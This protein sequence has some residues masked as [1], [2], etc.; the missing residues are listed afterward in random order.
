M[1][2]IVIR[3]AVSED[4]E[5][6]LKFIEELACYEKM[7]DAVKTNVQEIQATLFSKEATAHALICLENG[8]P[9][10]YAVY[11]YNYST[12]LGKNGLY[13][14][15]LYISPKH[16][17]QGAGK[18]ILKYLAKKALEKGCGRF[19][20]CVLDWNEPAIKFYE[21]IGAKAQNEWI[22]YR[23]SGEELQ[24]FAQK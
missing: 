10:G 13:L 2:K 7:Q 18:I 20:W 17:G 12:W 1:S 19:E 16:R 22:I 6:I 9:I 14:E 5:L 24:S 23:L 8:K 4:A 11:F 21:S 3:Q 15:D